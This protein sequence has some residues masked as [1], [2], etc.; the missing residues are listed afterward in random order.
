MEKFD[1]KRFV[2]RCAA[3]SYWLVDLE[4]DINNYKKTIMIN[5]VGAYIWKGLENGLSKE[6]IVIMLSKEC[7]VSANEI[8]ADVEYYLVQLEQMVSNKE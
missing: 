3:G 5:E 8:E 6:E 2:L 1:F 4:Q 7:N